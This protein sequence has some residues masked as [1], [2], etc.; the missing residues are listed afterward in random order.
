MNSLYFWTEIVKELHKQTLDLLRTRPAILVSLFVPILLI[1][2]VYVFVGGDQQS[3]VVLVPVSG[4]VTLDGKSLPN[5]TIIFKPLDG[6]RG[7][8]ATTNS[9]GIYE[10][11]YSKERSGVMLG[12]HAVTVSTG[13]LQKVNDLVEIVGELVPTRYNIDSNL[14]IDVTESNMSC[15][16][17]LLSR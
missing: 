3:D 1:F 17:V 6:N 11:K 2:L 14:T 4:H 12:K 10:L 15:D 5:A 16:L 7:S 13:K 8:H 9:K